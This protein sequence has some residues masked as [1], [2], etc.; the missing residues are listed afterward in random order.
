MS[1]QAI[2]PKLTLG[3]GHGASESKEGAPCSLEIW[4]QPGALHQ[5]LERL[6]YC[7]TRGSRY[8]PTRRPRINREV[9]SLS[10]YSV[11]PI[12]GERLPRVK[13]GFDA[14]G[15]KVDASG[16]KEYRNNG[17]GVCVGVLLC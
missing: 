7:S 3:N 17:S 9:P 13:A 1:D 15:T 5:E 6:L 10:A 16:T 11:L 14:P 8:A 12:L 2:A 4:L